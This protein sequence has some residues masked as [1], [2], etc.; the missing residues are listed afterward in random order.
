MNAWLLV[1]IAGLLEIV[2]AVALKLS[3]GFTR[4][5]PTLVTAVG[6][7]LSF[8]TL[9]LAMRDL[10]AGTA[11]A[12]WVGIGAVGVALFG[13]IWLAEPVNALRIGGIALIAVGIA[14]LKLA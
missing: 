8:W 3:D 2:W 12:V 10:P 1:S 4:P 6:A 13:V 14:A 5:L 9:S 7:A 11:Y